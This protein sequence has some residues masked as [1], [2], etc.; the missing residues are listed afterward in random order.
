M[1]QALGQQP[2]VRAAVYHR[3]STALVQ[4]LH[5]PTADRT[6]RGVREAVAACRGAARRMGLG[7]PSELR[8]EGDFGTLIAF[9][10]AEG[11]A[12]AWVDGQATPVQLEAL[13]SIGAAG[14][15]REEGRA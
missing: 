8:F 10:D 9:P 5:G 11:A 4:G 12:A 2:G 3:G 6:A 13:A 15:T 7:R 14:A 1:L